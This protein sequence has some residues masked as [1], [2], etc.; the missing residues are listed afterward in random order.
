MA[1]R[2]TRTPASAGN[3]LHWPAHPTIDSSDRDG[4][5]AP[6]HDSVDG[7]RGAPRRRC[8][9][10]ANPR[11]RWPVLAPDV[12]ASHG[13]GH[14]AE[15]GTSNRAA[16][17][18]RA[19]QARGRLSPV[20]RIPKSWRPPSRGEPRP[21]TPVILRGHAGRSAGRRGRKTGLM[22]AAANTAAR[23]RHDLQGKLVHR[24]QSAT[25]SDEVTTR[26]PQCRAR[27]RG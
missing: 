18:R 17:R 24:L 26:A 1:E 21:A 3:Y 13:S 22:W 23:D 8:L 19:R 15:G 4:A 14:P 11:A 7:A 6:H 10:R 9:V 2:E 16:L 5:E 20:K 27:R 25:G 12:T